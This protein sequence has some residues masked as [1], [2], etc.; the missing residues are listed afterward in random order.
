MTEWGPYDFKSPLIWNTN[1]VSASDS[2]QFEIIGSK[3]N[4]KII[5]QRGVKSISLL[6]GTMPAT[7]NAIKTNEKGQDVFIE[8]EYTG[9]NIT[10]PFGEKIKK[11]KPYRF[12]Y[13]N[14]LLPADWIVNWYAFDSAKNPIKN[15]AV[16]GELVKQTPLLTNHAADVNYAWW[17]GVGTEKK[18]EQFLTV[19]EAA[20]DFPPGDYE[21]GISWEDVVHIYIDGQLLLDEW[22]PAEHIYDESPHRELPVKLA[23]KHQIRVEQANQEGFATLIIKLKKK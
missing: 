4:W 6:N 9:E 16:I 19:A 7:V 17:N 23:G 11:E 21:M 10:T 2:M 8:L 22:K 18:Y 20:I 15:P 12:N 3:G 13:R 14:A 1:P 5:N